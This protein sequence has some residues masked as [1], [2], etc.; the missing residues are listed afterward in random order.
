MSATGAHYVK[1]NKISQT[2]ERQR[3]GACFHVRNPHLNL[4][5]HPGHGDSS[6]FAVT[7]KGETWGP[8]KHRER[9]GNSWGHSTPC[10]QG[11]TPSSTSCIRENP[12]LPTTSSSK[13]H[14]TSQCPAGHPRWAFGLCFF[15]RWFPKKRQ[16]SFWGRVKLWTQGYLK[17]WQCM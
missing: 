13:G 14:V 4:C 1:Q 7:V 17:P 6:R 11:Y 2:V 15:S 9:V 12:C 8:G 16:I 3:P 10:A 5:K